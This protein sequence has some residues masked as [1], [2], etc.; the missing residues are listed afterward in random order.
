MRW[1]AWMLAVTLVAPGSLLAQRAAPDSLANALELERTGQLAAAAK[2]FRAILAADPAEPSALLGLERVTG[3]GDSAATILPFAARAAEVA[4][5]GVS[6]GVLVRAYVAGG[7]ADSARA[8]VGRWAASAGGDAQPWREWVQAELRAR[9]RSAARGVVDLARAQL[10]DPD[11]LAYEMAQ[12]RIGEGNWSEAARE[13][14]GAISAFPGYQVAAGAA[15][16]R[17][18]EDQRAG[19]LHALEAAPGLDAQLLRAVL[20]ARWGNPADAIT[21]LVA[22][23][24]ERS[25]RAVQ[26]LGTFADQLRP[27]RDRAVSR[28]RGVAFEAIAQRTV[29]V[30]ASRARL[31]AARAYQDAGDNA[32]AERVLAVVTQDEGATASTPA[33]GVTLVG[34]LVDAGKMEEAEQKFSEVGPALTAEDRDELRRQ[35]AW[36]WVRAGQLDHALERLTGDSTV[37]GLA[38]RGQIAIFRGDLKNGA[39]LLRRAGPYAGSR[40]AVTDRIA[41]LSLLQPI[42]DDSLPAL[43]AALLTL[44]RGDSATATGQLEA[45]ADRLPPAD[46]GA[47]VRLLA[48]QLARRTGDAAKAEV[49]LRAAD[50]SAA[51]AVAA[52]AELELAR[53]MQATHRQGQ[54]IHQLEHLILTYPGSAVVPEARR[55]LDEAK[56][57]VP[58]P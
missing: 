1:Q 26:A 20:A 10:K 22:A 15:L 37:D 25:P 53:L 42:Q 49:L 13:W 56:G 57:A 33:A 24:P 14:V 34:V 47:A 44:A 29:G 21:Q 12:I 32:A 3:Q 11:A 27:S 28:A 55:A 45:V 38:L 40:E 39:E 43:G 17:A 35:L 23:L 18:P 2:A 51:P 54:A 4:P 50:D 46:G 16:A 52:A 7:N 36:G 30:A 8:V 58:A 9:D 6:Y 5:G 31:N 48:G 19:I 41:L